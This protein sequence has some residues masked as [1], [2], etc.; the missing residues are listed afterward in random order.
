VSSINKRSAPRR[1]QSRRVEL[2]ASTPTDGLDGLECE[3]RDISASGARIK[4]PYDLA[5]YAVQWPKFL[6]LRIPMDRVE[7]DCIL[8]RVRSHELGLRFA[9]AFRLLERRRVA[10]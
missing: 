2:F 8:V 3:L 1:A 4:L 9:S 6:K 7:V 5:T 10:A